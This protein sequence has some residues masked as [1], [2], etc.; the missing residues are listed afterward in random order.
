M[1][2]YGAG[3]ASVRRDRTG[4]SLFDTTPA[5]EKWREQ[6]QA[7]AANVRAKYAGDGPY[8]VAAVLADVDRW[9]RVATQFKTAAD[10]APLSTMRPDQVKRASDNAL[11][12]LEA[13]AELQVR[14]PQAV[15]ITGPE[16]H[17]LAEFMAAPIDWLVS[18][19]EPALASAE[20]PASMIKTAL[21]IVGGIAGI[22]A[23]TKLI[24]SGVSAKRE[25][26][27]ERPLLAP[28]ALV[29]NPPAW[30]ADPILWEDARMAVEPHRAQYDNPEAVIVHVYKQMGGRVS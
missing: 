12:L 21:W 2:V 25:I 17:K 14:V 1:S 23:L 4:G 28:R 8:Q 22:W 5:T 15:S 3:A 10:T 9:W 30:A 27:G 29:R 18:V 7:A 20:A 13:R 26:V 19:G 11:N 24:D 16:A 6:M